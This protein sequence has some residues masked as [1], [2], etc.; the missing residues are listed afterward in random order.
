MVRRSTDH[1]DHDVGVGEHGDVGACNPVVVVVAPIRFATKRSRSGWT[2]RSFSATMYQLGFDLQAVPSTFLL[3]RSAFGTPWV[4]QTS[5]TLCKRAARSVS[6]EGDD[7]TSLRTVGQ[8]RRDLDVQDI[9][10][11]G[12]FPVELESNF[13]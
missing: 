9:Q 11:S 4:A 3:N 2:V 12:E 8:R 5:S 1:V 13:S 10:E 6:A 7:G